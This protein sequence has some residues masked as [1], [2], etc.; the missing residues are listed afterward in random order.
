MVRHES[1]WQNRESLHER[2]RRYRYKSSFL[3]ECLIWQRSPSCLHC[4][5]GKFFTYLSWRFHNALLV[6]HM[7]IGVITP[8]F[9]ILALIIG[10][11]YIMIIRHYLKTAR[12]VNRLCSMLK[13]PV[14]SHVSESNN[15][16]I[17]VRA[18]KKIDMFYNE[19]VRRANTKNRGKLNQV[20]SHRWINLRTDFVGSFIVGYFHNCEHLSYF[21][22]ILAVQPCLEYLQ[23]DI[24]TPL[25]LL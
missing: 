12:E 10:V 24:I 23:R 5:H 20:Y 19:Y 9:F 4:V 3:Y 6:Y 1:K 11:Y 25:I 8:L 14:M 13:A 16:L 18:F 21:N 15:G 2:S 22:L 7:K 17:T